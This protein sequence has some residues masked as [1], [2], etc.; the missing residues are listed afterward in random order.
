MKTTTLFK[1]GQSQAVRI[2]KEFRMKGRK[3]Y[4]KRS[5][6]A[7]VLLP[8]KNSWQPLLESLDQFSDDL[9]IERNQPKEQQKRDDI[10]K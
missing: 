9:V 4:I 8:V 10:G 1:N 5:G 6:D 2:P 3:V 7:V